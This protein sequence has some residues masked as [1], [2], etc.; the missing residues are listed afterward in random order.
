LQEFELQVYVFD[1]TK[2]AHITKYVTFP[3][4]TF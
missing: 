4:L 1:H 2:L 3:T